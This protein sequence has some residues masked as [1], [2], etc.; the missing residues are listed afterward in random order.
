LIENSQLSSDW[1]ALNVLRSVALSTNSVAASVEPVMQQQFF[2]LSPM[3]GQESFG[4]TGHV[5]AHTPTTSSMLAALQQ[6]SFHT[7]GGLDHTS[8]SQ[9]GGDAYSGMGGFIDNMD[10]AGSAGVVVDDGG[11][12]GLFGDYSSSGFDA[13][14][15]GELS[16]ITSATPEVGGSEDSGVKVEPAP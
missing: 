15:S 11:A 16:A 5:L 1:I 14:G 2:S 12:A 13:F 9:F 7:G 8:A 3:A 10:T 6:D 4:P